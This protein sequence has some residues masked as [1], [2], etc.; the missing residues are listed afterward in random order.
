L[1]IALQAA[2]GRITV[3]GELSG[4]AVRARSKRHR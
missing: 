4:I 1:G 3:L 2:L